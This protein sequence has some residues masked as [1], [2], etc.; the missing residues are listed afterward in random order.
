[1]NKLNLT[2]ELWGLILEASLALHSLFEYFLQSA[3][4][5]VKYMNI[6]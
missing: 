6:K 1:M 4:Q 3:S 5:Y 2:E